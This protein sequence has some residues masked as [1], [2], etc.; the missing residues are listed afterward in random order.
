VDGTES[1]LS[2][3]SELYEELWDST[4]GERDWRDV[5]LVR[6]AEELCDSVEQGMALGLLGSNSRL[7]DLQS[8]SSSE[9]SAGDVTR[10]TTPD[11]VASDR[12]DRCK[13]ARAREGRE[14]RSPDGERDRADCLDDVVTEAMGV[15]TRWR[16]AELDA[17]IARGT[18]FPLSEVAE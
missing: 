2:W 12:V 8:C 6:W 11:P 1:V 7:H 15:S 17:C 9:P 16:G 5:S 13:V 10:T 4:E 18:A 14:R 3:L